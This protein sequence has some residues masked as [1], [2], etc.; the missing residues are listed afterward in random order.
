MTKEAYKNKRL[1]FGTETSP[2]DP[3]FQTEDLGDNSMKASEYGI[4]NLKRILPNLI[5]WSKEKGEDYSELEGLYNSLVGQFRRYMGHVTKNVGGIYENPKTYDMEGN[6]YEITPSAIQNEAVAFL[7]EQL[8]K[9]PTWLLDQNVLA[10]I[11]PDNGVELMKGIQDGTLSSLLSLDRMA[12]LMETSS[13]NKANY[14][15]DELMSDL[16][17]GIFSELR[18]NTAIDV[19]RRNL[20]KAYVSK[21]ID[22]ISL[23][24]NAAANF[25]GRRIVIADTDLPSI[26]RGHLIELRSQ[27]KAANALTTDRLSKFHIADLVARIDK[28]LNPNR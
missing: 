25:N 16:K 2:Y 24:K 1:Q 20:Q 27:L 19:Y 9:T 10:K 22:A 8:F 28:A 3:R 14:S 23:D 11:N 15:I 12:R 5:E 26:A 18:T 17:R 4:K 21:L 13:M 6:E 7:N